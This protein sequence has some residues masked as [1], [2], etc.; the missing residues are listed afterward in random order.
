MACSEPSHTGYLNKQ[1]NC[2]LLAL[3]NQSLGEKIH[4]MLQALARLGGDRENAHARTNRLNFALEKSCVAHRG[5]PD[6]R[7]EGPWV[8][9]R[10]LQRAVSLH[11]FHYQLHQSIDRLM[12]I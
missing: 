10:Y 3:L 2:C 12:D 9:E 11:L 5:F 7:K 1:L 8:S 6:G 4:V